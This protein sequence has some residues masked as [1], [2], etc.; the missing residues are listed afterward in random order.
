MS[1]KKIIYKKPI[2]SDIDEMQK[3]VQPE[4]ESGIILYRSADEIATN[5]RSYFIARTDEKII[6]FCALHVYSKKLAEIRSIIIDKNYRGKHIGK[7]LI[8]NL[9]EE[10][11]L[12]GINQLFALTYE[13]EFFRHMGFDEIEKEKLPEQKIWTDCIKCKHFPI[14]NEIAFIK[15]I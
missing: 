10:G 14:C 5:I 4:I 6:G 13:K 2:L 1:N 12:L 15:Q 3:L 9:I 8:L 7:N 11:K